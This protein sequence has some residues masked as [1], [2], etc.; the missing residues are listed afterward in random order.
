MLEIVFRYGKEGFATDNV[1][2]AREK[3]LALPG[4]P[5]AMAFGLSC[6]R[7]LPVKRL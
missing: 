4:R 2:F 6:R 7:K 5:A 3:G 1:D